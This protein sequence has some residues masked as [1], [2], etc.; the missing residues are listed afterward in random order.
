MKLR[1]A[2]AI[3][4]LSIA[5]HVARAAVD[6]VTLGNAPTPFYDCCF[7]PLDEVYM[8]LH[9]PPLPKQ[10][11]LAGAFST[12]FSIGYQ[13][14]VA[15]QTYVR[16]RVTV[17]LTRQAAYLGH[18]GEFHPGTNYHVQVDFVY[19]DGNGN[20]VT[21]TNATSATAYPGDV[22]W[23]YWNAPPPSVRNAGI[24]IYTPQGALRSLN[25]Y[26]FVF[27]YGPMPNAVAYPKATFTRDTS[28]NCH[29]LPGPIDDVN[30]DGQFN[31]YTMYATGTNVSDQH[32][33]Q[34]MAQYLGNG[35]DCGLQ[36]FPQPDGTDEVF[37]TP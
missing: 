10:P 33:E 15:F 37:W 12:E 2:L 1:L 23:V 30:P 22:L 36:M 11:S 18:F 34:G 24:V 6:T 25:L 14:N 27:P 26:D 16:N 35:S 8:Y 9:A 29:D 32:L 5:P 20:L 13:P 4:A 21:R 31:L 3:L 28:Y 19:E 7:S 17:K